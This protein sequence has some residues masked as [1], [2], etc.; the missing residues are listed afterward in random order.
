LPSEISEK[1]LA[2]KLFSKN[3]DLDVVINTLRNRE[4]NRFAEGVFEKRVIEDFQRG[5]G[6]KLHAQRG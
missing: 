2:N 4:L 6:S 5:L 3:D 1:L